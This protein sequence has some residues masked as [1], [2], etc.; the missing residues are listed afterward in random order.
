MRISQPPAKMA[1]LLLL[2]DIYVAPYSYD[3]LWCF[4]IQ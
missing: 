2:Y 4:T 1:I 3:V